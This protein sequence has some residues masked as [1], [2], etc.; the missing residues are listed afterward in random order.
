MITIRREKSSGMDILIAFAYRNRVRSAVLSMF[1]KH[2][3][4]VG[5]QARVRR[6][7]LGS[8]M[9]PYAVRSSRLLSGQKSEEFAGEISAPQ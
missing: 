4:G 7:R 5:T 1:L 3:F 8:V 6:Q 9:K 2:A